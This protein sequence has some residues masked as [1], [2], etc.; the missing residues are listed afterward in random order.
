MKPVCIFDFGNV[1]IR[2]SPAY[3]TG[4]YVHDPA[5]AKLVREVMFD[6]LYWD[7]LDEGS[8][9]DSE[10]KKSACQ[11]I[12]QRLQEDACRVYDHWYEH[13]PEI[14]G[15]RTLLLDLKAAGRKLYLLSNISLGFEQGYPRVP[16]LREL[17]SLFDGC[18]FSGSIGMVK[19]CEKIYLHLLSKYELRREDCVFIDDSPLNVR[20][21]LHVGMESIRFDGNVDSLRE[22]LLPEG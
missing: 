18:V 2:F 22:R 7:R 13:L 20:G 1:L 14:K 8:I 3:I 6:R 16:A 21:A 19:P 10:V 17:L 9:T 11:R 15:M 5:D 4:A 12:P